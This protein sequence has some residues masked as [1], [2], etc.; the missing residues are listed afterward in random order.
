MAKKKQEIIHLQC[1]ECKM[2]NYTIRRAVKSGI[3]RKE[4]LELNKYCSKDRKR[5]IHKEIKASKKKK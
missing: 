5:T 2:Q 4:K 3:E 1:T